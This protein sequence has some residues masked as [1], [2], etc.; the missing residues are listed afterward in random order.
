MRFSAEVIPTGRGQ[1]GPFSDGRTIGYLN[2]TEADG[3]DGDRATAGEGVNLETVE[4]FKPVML[5]FEVYV[6][7]SEGGNKRKLR[8]FG[9]SKPAVSRVAA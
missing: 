8:T 2:F 5:D 9:P 3:G 4:L 6:T 7:S 1:Y